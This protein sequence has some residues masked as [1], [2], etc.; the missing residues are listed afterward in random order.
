MPLCLSIESRI[1]FNKSLDTNPPIEAFF[2]TLI[3]WTVKNGAISVS[4]SHDV[5]GKL[6]SIVNTAVNIIA[7]KINV[8]IMLRAL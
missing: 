8:L 6:C 1:V 5:P 7:Q 4:L 3:N 2:T